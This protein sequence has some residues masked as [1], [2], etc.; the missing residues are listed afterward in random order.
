MSSEFHCACDFLSISG[1]ISRHKFGDLLCLDFDL[2][3][4]P[5]IPFSTLSI[6]SFGHILVILGFGI[7][8]FKFGAGTFVLAQVLVNQ[9]SSVSEGSKKFS[10][11]IF[12]AAWGSGVDGKVN[13]N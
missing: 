9:G 10:G 7:E 2:F 11:T 8:L 4:G 13:L 3:P 12:L 5:Y 1:N 6:Q